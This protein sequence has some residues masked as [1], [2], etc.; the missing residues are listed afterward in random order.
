MLIA[1]G[2]RDTKVG[3]FKYGITSSAD[4]S[5]RDRTHSA[6]MDLRQG[7]RS[8]PDIKG[9]CFC[10]CLASGYKEL[11]FLPLKRKFLPGKDL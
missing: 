10:L 4:L 2:K 3:Y 11:D 6:F 5:K 1:S 7:K 9:P 8:K